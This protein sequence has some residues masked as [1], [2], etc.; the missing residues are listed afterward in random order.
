MPLSFEQ[1]A[2]ILKDHLN[3][4]EL[5]HGA[6]YAAEAPIPVGERLRFSRIMIDVPWPAHLGFVDREPQANWGHPCR[7]ILINRETGELASFEARFPPFNTGIDLHW[8]VVYKA[9]GVP[10]SALAVR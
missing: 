6:A 3:L 10:D 9:R 1:C 2:S 5:N 4:D 7:Y 8:R